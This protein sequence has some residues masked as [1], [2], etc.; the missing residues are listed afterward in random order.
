MAVINCVLPISRQQ[1]QT[2]L[3]GIGCVQMRAKMGER[4]MRHHAANTTVGDAAIVELCIPFRSCTVPVIAYS[5]P[6]IVYLANC[7][8]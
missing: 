8:Y 7:P 4:A 6:A 5:N 1:A 3:V 2:F